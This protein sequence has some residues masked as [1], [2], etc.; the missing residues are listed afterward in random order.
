ML[1]I[2]ID[3]YKVAYEL[4]TTCHRI[5]TICVNANF[6]KIW[7]QMTIINTLPTTGKEPVKFLDIWVHV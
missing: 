7:G 1:Y 6:L 3:A 5:N 2:F 4:K